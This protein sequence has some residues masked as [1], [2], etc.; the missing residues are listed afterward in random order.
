MIPR[1]G[2]VTT[3]SQLS[4]ENP[5]SAVLT[6]RGIAKLYAALIGEVD[7]VRLVRPEA[8]PEITGP[9]LIAQDE[10]MGNPAT[11]ALGY[12]IG[13]LGSTAEESPTSFGMPGMGGSVA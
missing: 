5:S 13:R 1:A 9:A 11:W 4:A 8:I 3:P 12:S 7:G 6:A 10:L 2:H